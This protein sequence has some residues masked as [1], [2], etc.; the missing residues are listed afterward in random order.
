MLRPILALVGT[1]MLAVAAPANAVLVLNMSEVF[2]G[3]DCA[4]DLGIPP[5]CVAYDSPM[6]AKFDFSPES[7]TPGA[8]PSIDGSEFAFTG[9]GTPSGTFTY[10]PNDAD[11][12]GIKFWSLKAGDEYQIFWFTNDVSG[13]PDAAVTVP[14]GEAVD[15]ATTSGKDISHITFFDSGDQQRMPEPGSLALLGLG[16]LGAVGLTRRRRS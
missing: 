10:S 4:G 2:A 11:D 15:W 12:P 14:T 5:N 6:I 1:A 13:G 8:F 9:G 3:N 7:F 16:L